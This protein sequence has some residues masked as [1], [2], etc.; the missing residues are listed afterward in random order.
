MAFG[1]VSI[2]FVLGALAGGGGGYAF[3]QRHRAAALADEMTEGKDARRMAMLSREL[4]LTPKQ[5]ADVSA[6]YEKHRGKRA[7]LAREMFERCGQAARKERD[8]VDAEVRA[9][10]TDEQKLRF[11][12]WQ[13]RRRDSFRGA[14]PVE[15]SAPP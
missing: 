3:A 1:A 8:Q 13:K 9:V 2:A 15:S 12:E 14:A 4:D 11:D 7:E 6:V 10:L 5:A